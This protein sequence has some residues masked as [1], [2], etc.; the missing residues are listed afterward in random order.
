[1]T[2]I[3]TSF[4]LM[5]VTIGTFV[6]ILS[7]KRASKFLLKHEFLMPLG[8]LLLFVSTALLAVDKRTMAMCVLRRILPG[9]G[10]TLAFI[11][12]LLQVLFDFDKN[13]YQCLP[14]QNGENTKQF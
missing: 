2:I 10:Y 12:M 8:V 5:S 13:V 3:G 7:V 11:G 14:C 1:M 9:L 6:L 4:G